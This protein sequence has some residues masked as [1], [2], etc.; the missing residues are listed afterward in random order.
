MPLYA[1]P[2]VLV[3]DT[4]K[5]KKLGY[6]AE[7]NFVALET[8][9][10]LIKDGGAVALRGGESLDF[11]NLIT[12]GGTIAEGTEARAALLLET[13]RLLESENPRKAFQREE[14]FAAVIR[15]SELKSLYGDGPRFGLWF[16]PGSEKVPACLVDRAVAFGM[17]QHMEG[18]KLAQALDFIAFLTGEKAGESLWARNLC[19]AYLNHEIKVPGREMENLYRYAQNCVGGPP[20]AA[21]ANTISLW[22]KEVMLD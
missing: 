12:A 7:S 10:A 1:D 22:R 15:L 2:T 18:E 11:V 3:Y 20:P 5:A 8:F 14:V 17:G 19:P 16:Y 13:E 6:R 9:A 4:V 21:L